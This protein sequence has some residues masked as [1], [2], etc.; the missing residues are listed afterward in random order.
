MC[1]ALRLAV[2]KHGIKPFPSHLD[3]DEIGVTSNLDI[4]EANVR[5]VAHLGA[6]DKQIAKRSQY[7]GLPNRGAII[8]NESGLYSLILKSR[9]GKG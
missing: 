4:G 6:A 1:E 5:A 8:I 9:C 7:E 3:A 2:R